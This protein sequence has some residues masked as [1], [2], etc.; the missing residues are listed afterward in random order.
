MKPSP[1][2]LLCALCILSVSCN[3]PPPATSS[4][5]PLDKGAVASIAGHP[6]SRADF[7]LELAR[8]S[9]AST[10]ID[11]REV[12]LADMIDSEAVYVR[13]IEAGFDQKPEIARQIKRL[14]V[15][16]FI[17]DQLRVSPESIEVA[18]T[19]VKNYYEN[20]AKKYATPEQTR[21]AVIYFSFSP[22]AAA[23]N[24]KAIAAQAA[25]ALN[26]AH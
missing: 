8:R 22:K 9:R 7:E 20:H 18:Q 12:L 3:P 26:E 4:V 14:I 24:K 2:S 19:E 16:Q 25:H 21:F 17:E 23:E 5:A 6:I 10:P 15:N 13:A 11:Q 1:L